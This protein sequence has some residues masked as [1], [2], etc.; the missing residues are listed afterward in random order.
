VPFCAPDER[1]MLVVLARGSVL[2]QGMP[3]AES[4]ALAA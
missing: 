3:I 1:P 2:A 4:R